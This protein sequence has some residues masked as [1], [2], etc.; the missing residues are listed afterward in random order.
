[1]ELCPLPK[2][3]QLVEDWY[4]TLMTGEEVLEPMGSESNE[5][6]TRAQ[7]RLTGCMTPFHGGHTSPNP[8]QPGPLL[9]HQR[10]PHC[11]HLPDCESSSFTQ[12]WPSVTQSEDRTVLRKMKQITKT[13]PK[14]WR[15]GDIDSGSSLLFLICWFLSWQ[16]HGQSYGP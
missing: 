8:S 13:A 6:V 3:T 7:H 5:Q 4:P 10:L 14:W 9:S 11:S 1:M 12:G 15:K 2:I 16:S